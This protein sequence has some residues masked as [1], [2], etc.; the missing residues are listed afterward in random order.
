MDGSELYAAADALFSTPPR[1]CK[2][3]RVQGEAKLI[4]LKG[5]S[6]TIG[7]W[8]VI[9]VP[10][11]DGLGWGCTRC[12]PPPKKPRTDKKRIKSNTVPMF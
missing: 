4:R 9:P 11:G 5:P 8:S 12:F 3:G 7:T 1:C 6:R 2:C 10:V